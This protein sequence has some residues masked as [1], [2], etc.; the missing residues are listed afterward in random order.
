MSPVEEVCYDEDPVLCPEDSDHPGRRS[1][2]VSP[3]RGLLRRRRPRPVTCPEGTEKA[4]EEIHEGEDPEEFCADDDDE[5]VCP[6][7]TDHAGEEVAHGED[8]ATFCDDDDIDPGPTCKD[9]PTLPGCDENTPG[10]PSN[11][12]NGPTVKGA[13]ATAP[14]AVVGASAGTPTAQVPSA[15]NAGLGSSEP[16]GNDGNLGLLG[17][18]T[19]LLGAA[20]VGLTVRPRRRTG[21]AA[22]ART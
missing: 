10:S 22:G 1:W 18:A 3:S 12:N 19:A 8:P 4:G 16:S 6:E 5:E 15:I 17:V 2:R 7:G 9:D 21:A 14:T 20:M 13:Q 11:P